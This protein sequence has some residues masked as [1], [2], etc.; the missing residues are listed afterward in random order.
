MIVLSLVCQVINWFMDGLRERFKIAQE[1]KLT[2]YL[3]AKYKWRK[4]EDGQM[5]CDATMKKKTK[6]IVDHNNNKIYQKRS[7]RI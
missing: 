3:G 1:G 7:Q 6:A 2:K 4:I 5:F